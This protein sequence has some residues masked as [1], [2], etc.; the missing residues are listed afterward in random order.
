MI[1]KMKRFAVLMISVVVSFL[2]S[3]TVPVFAQTVADAARQERE[4]KKASAHATH[5]YT[6]EDLVKPQILV[7]EDQ[8]RAAG[9]D[10]AG[11]VAASAPSEQPAATSSS[12][13]AEPS[14]SE[15]FPA[16]V[17]SASMKAKPQTREAKPAV[18]GHIFKTESHPSPASEATKHATVAAIPAP[19][20]LPAVSA[21]QIPLPETNLPEQ[22][23]VASPVDNATQML[24]VPE[25]GG[26]SFSAA[27]T[28]SGRANTMAPQVVATDQESVSRPLVVVTDVTKSVPIPAQRRV[29]AEPVA[30]LVTRSSVTPGAVHLFVTERTMVGRTGP[31]LSP[32]TGPAPENRVAKVSTRADMQPIRT[33]TAPSPNQ[34]PA[35]LASSMAIAAESGTV[36]VQPGDS[37]WKLAQRYLKAGERWKEIAKLNPQLANP[38]LIRP[39]ELIQVPVPVPTEVKKILVQPGDTLWSVAQAQFGRPLA[40]SCIAHANQLQSVNVIRVGQTLVMPEDC[41]VSR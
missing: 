35:S 41:A 31:F 33:K 24:A 39:G 13:P 9:G 2:L 38:S 25:P 12:A 23:Q 30:P 10:E 29:T 5:V 20:E 7:P 32:L 22:L 36:H 11:A 40:F 8:A 1:T 4:R 6:N 28:S 26:A 3:T 18:S 21:G 27:P 34:L 19:A 15:S 37:L 17:I 16:P 14:N